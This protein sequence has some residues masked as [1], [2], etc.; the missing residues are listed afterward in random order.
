MLIFLSKK[1]KAAKDHEKL[2]ALVKSLSEEE[3]LIK[4]EYHSGERSS[5]YGVR[6]IAGKSN[7]YEAYIIM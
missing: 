4:K 2:I 3:K 1:E 7:W 6:P 5:L